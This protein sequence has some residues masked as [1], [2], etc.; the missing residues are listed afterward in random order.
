MRGQTIVAYCVLLVVCSCSNKNGEDSGR[1]TST[2][3]RIV[4][5]E[6]EDSNRHQTEA[7][8]DTLGKPRPVVPLEDMTRSQLN[9][10]KQVLAQKGFYSCCVEP[11][12]RMCL[13]EFEECPC[14]HNLKKKQPV[15]GE[16]FD[17]W[18]N[19]RGKIKG[20]KPEDV[21]KM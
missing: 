4:Q 3:L 20:I 12:C 8:F 15:C 14:E 10:Y 2:P 6:A 13:F 5:G 17:K 11:S 18:H 7:L 19:G 1:R 9:K 16:C 21:K